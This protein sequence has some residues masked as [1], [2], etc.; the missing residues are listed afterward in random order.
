MHTYMLYL[1]THMCS[2]CV[3]S[4][5]P[6]FP[7]SGSVS[8]SIRWV[9]SGTGDLVV[10]IWPCITCTV[11]GRMSLG[12]TLRCSWFLLISPCGVS[13]L[14]L[15]RHLLSYPVHEYSVG[16]NHKHF[17]KDVAGKLLTGPKASFSTC[18]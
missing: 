11:H 16:F 10:V 15:M 4:H 5:I 13:Y 2:A 14:L 17:A 18:A 3:S 1:V 9:E 7:F 6:H 12:T 8:S